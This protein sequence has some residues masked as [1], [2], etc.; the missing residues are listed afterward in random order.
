MP[1]KTVRDG[2]EQGGGRAVEVAEV[3]LTE[4]SVSAPPPPYP[5]ER[6]HKLRMRCKALASGHSPIEAHQTRSCNPT[7]RQ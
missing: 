1:G 4:S 7:P 6:L 5:T 3:V 2:A